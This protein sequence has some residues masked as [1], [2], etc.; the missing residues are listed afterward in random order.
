MTYGNHYDLQTI[1]PIR[2]GKYLNNV[3]KK[4]EHSGGKVADKVAETSLSSKSIAGS[5]KCWE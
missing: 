1:R 5:R 4:M 2:I 3:L